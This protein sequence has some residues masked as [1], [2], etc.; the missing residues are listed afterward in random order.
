M[1]GGT[2]CLCVVSPNKSFEQIDQFLLSS[3]GLSLLYHTPEILLNS[4][5]LQVQK[6]FCWEQ[7]R[8]L[9]IFM[10][11]ELLLRKLF[12]KWEFVDYIPMMKCY[13]VCDKWISNSVIL[14]NYSKV[15]EFWNAPH[16][17]NNFRAT[18]IQNS[19]LSQILRIYI[20][21]G[22]SI[23]KLDNWERKSSN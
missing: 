18:H 17:V 15:C 5:V 6:L 21:L 13:H 4:P 2:C 12:P 23:S 19:K 20:V 1:W 8:V 9:K 16:V 11:I 10:I 22:N 7:C 14:I 3:I